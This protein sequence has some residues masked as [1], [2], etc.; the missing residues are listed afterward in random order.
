[1]DF[2]LR[3]DR[4]ELLDQP[5]IPAADIERNLHELSIINHLLGGHACTWKGFAELADKSETAVVCE[6]GCGGGDNLKTIELKAVGKYPDISFT[7][8]DINPDCIRVAENIKW[9]KPVL[10]LV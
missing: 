8:V 4:P 3:T 6:I 9:K 1:M 5:N 2:S 10:F 7:G